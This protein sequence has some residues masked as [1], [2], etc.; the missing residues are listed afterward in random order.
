MLKNLELAFRRRGLFDGNTIYGFLYLV[1]GTLEKAWYIT[2]HRED[3]E[4]N[5]YWLVGEEFHAVSRH[6]AY[7]MTSETRIE[8]HGVIRDIPDR[9]RQVILSAIK[10]WV[11]EYQNEL[12]AN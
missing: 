5:N 8:V 4:I 1:S 3:G 12:I 9:E 7:Q 11:E 10:Q 2:A 6:D